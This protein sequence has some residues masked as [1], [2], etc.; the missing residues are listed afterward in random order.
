VPAQQKLTPVDASSKVNFVIKNFAI[1]TNGQLSGL[2]GQ[3]IFD[4]NDLAK[5]SFDISVDV[6]TINTDNAR[7]DKHLKAED[8]FDVARY[9]VIRIVG[10]AVTVAGNSY[11]LKGNLTIKN[12]TKAVEIPFTATAQGRGVV[13]EGAFRINRLDYSVGKESATM[14]DELNITLKVL[15]E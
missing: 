2:K 12:I 11:V 15:A 4:R 10:R 13:F 14:A 9:P 7:R 8:F 1:N 5:S 6:A 3:I